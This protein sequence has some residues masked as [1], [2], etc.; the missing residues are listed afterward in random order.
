VNN[1]GMAENI[2]GEG[3]YNLIRGN[4]SRVVFYATV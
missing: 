3:A 1:N 2:I 4:I